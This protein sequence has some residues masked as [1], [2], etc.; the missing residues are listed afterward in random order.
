[1]ASWSELWVSSRSK[2]VTLIRHAY[3]ATE[4]L[5]RKPRQPQPP[6]VT[7]CTEGA[8]GFQHCVEQPKEQEGHILADKEGSAR[9]GFRRSLDAPFQMRSQ[10]TLK[11]LQ[12]C[13]SAACSSVQVLRDWAFMEDIDP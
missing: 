12:E 9:I 3:V 11:G 5:D 1:M 8:G 6:G 7:G 2:D 4:H 13:A 10:A